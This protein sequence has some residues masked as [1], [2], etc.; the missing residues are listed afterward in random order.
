METLVKLLGALPANLQALLS[1]P[2][3]NRPDGDLLPS[4]A[5]PSFQFQVEDTPERPSRD[6]KQ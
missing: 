6:I 5:P 4:I 2:N 1:D 3:R